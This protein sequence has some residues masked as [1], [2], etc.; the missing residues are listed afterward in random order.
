MRPPPKAPPCDYDHRRDDRVVAAGRRAG[1]DSVASLLATFAAAIEQAHLGRLRPAELAVVQ[2]LAV[3]PDQARIVLSYIKAFFEAIPDLG[4]M[5]TRETR[6]GLE[7]N[8]GVSIEEGVLATLNIPLSFITPQQWKNY[9]GIK[10][11]KDEAKDAARSESG[12]TLARQ[13]RLV[14]LH[15]GRW[16]RRIVPDSGRTAIATSR[17]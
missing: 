9:I 10:P 16:S 2:C 8:N 3:D 12:S 6:F 14:C 5:V 11:G 15:Q 1:K 7:L 13:R 17:R 4:A